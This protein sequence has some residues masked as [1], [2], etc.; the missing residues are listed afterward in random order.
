MISEPM[1]SQTSISPP[2]LGR[3]LVDGG[4]QAWIDC[5]LP[6]DRRPGGTLPLMRQVQIVVGTVSAIGAALALAVDPWFA[7][8]P[9]VTGCGLLF[10]GLTGFCGMALLLAK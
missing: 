6:V 3:L 8:I 7:V 5:G 9:L 2:D 10:A 1:Q 4:M